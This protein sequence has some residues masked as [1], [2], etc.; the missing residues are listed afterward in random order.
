VSQWYQ[1]WGEN[2]VCYENKQK[3][4]KAMLYYNFQNNPSVRRIILF[5]CIMVLLHCI[6]YNSPQVSWFHG[7]KIFM[8]YFKPLF[9]YLHHVLYS[10]QTEFRQFWFC[11]CPG[12]SDVRGCIQ[13]FRN[14]SITKY[15][16]T[17]T[18]WES[19]QSVM[20]A[21]DTRLTHKIAIQQHLLAESC[22]IFSSRSR[23]PV[24]K[25]LIPPRIVVVGLLLYIHHLQVRCWTGAIIWTLYYSSEF[26]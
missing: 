16:K 11:R 5:F 26:S 6:R 7:N 1:S 20:A 23:R 18:R 4:I 22:T 2:A 9:H 10:F 13:I 3:L 15:T 19:T 14:D 25:H 17:N 24:R 21:K 12:W 8:L